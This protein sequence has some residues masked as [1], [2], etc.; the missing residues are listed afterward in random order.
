MAPQ[1]IT[2]PV[3]GLT[4]EAREALIG[5]GIV[6][7]E[8]D[9]PYFADADEEPG[10][11]NPAAWIIDAEI[12]EEKEPSPAPAPAREVAESRPDKDKPR[13][14]PPTLDEWQDLISR[15]LLRFIT[16]WYISFAFRGISEDQLSERDVQRL[17]MTAEERRQ[18]ALPLAELANKSKI[19]RKHGRTIIAAAGSFESLMTLGIWFSRVNRIAAK[20]PRNNSRPKKGSNN[21][22]TGQNAQN[23]NGNGFVPP[24]SMRIYSPGTG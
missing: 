17:A 2:P 7:A 1:P 24:E 9:E 15:I 11:E 10:V 3:A 19:T 4:Q 23:G 6:S 12:I 21:V 5:N 14:G 13:S 22:G 18:V 20:Y 8:Q 16:E